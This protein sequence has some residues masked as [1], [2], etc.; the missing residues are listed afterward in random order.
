MTQSKDSG[1]LLLRTTNK[2]SSRSK[3]YTA[4]V[5]G[6]YTVLVLFLV[7]NVYI[8]IMHIY[9][10]SPLNM[11]QQQFSQPHNS[12]D[13]S[14]AK[15]EM[16]LGNNIPQRVEL[17]NNNINNDNKAANTHAHKNKTKTRTRTRNGNGII[18]KR[19][20]ELLHGAT[21]QRL[22]YINLD[23]NVKRR[24]FMESWLS[25]NSS[26]SFP[27]QRVPASDGQDVDKKSNEQEDAVASCVP[28]KRLPAG[29][30]RGIAGVARSN[31]DIID[32]YNTSGLT[33]VAEDD[34]YFHDMDKIMMYIQKVPSDWDIIRFDCNG[35]I[36]A[37]FGHVVRSLGAAQIFETAHTR[38]CN[39]ST[40]KCQFCG[41][42]Y[43]MV[44]RESS[45][46][47]LRKIWSPV[48]YDDID[49]RL[50]NANQLKSYCVQ[51]RNR[52]VA[53]KPPP[54]E[55]TDIPIGQEIHDAQGSKLWV[56]KQK[57]KKK[58]KEGLQ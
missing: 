51:T 39:A 22:Y 13:N 52:V 53:H 45:I 38:P 9:P 30:C 49:C 58:G 48:P 16:P 56:S 11:F 50:S 4:A 17:N 44:W 43:A 55:I 32:N 41:G 18:N 1:T 33:F 31:L 26:N 21:I 15:H 6:K 40:Q 57:R 28:S 10:S 20:L 3:S 46:P 14:N 7:A 12:I 5:S 36:P 47:K 35:F 54:G 2:K 29:R 42:T 24:E 27:F 34:I 19:D 25:K 37:T 8:L 23:K